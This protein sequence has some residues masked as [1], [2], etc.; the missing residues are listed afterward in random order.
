MA[1]LLTVLTVSPSVFPERVSRAHVSATSSE[2][3]PLLRSPDGPCSPAISI[4]RLARRFTHTLARSLAPC[5][6]LSLAPTPLPLQLAVL[7]V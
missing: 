2:A 7:A 4:L 6:L 3:R 5:A 1:A